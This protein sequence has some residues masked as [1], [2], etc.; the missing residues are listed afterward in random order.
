MEL[1]CLVK[2][3]IGG[4]AVAP[5]EFENEVFVE[6]AN[7]KLL[8]CVWKLSFSCLR[9]SVIERT[10]D[11]ER[12]STD[13]LA[14][15]NLLRAHAHTHTRHLILG[16]LILNVVVC[17]KIQS[18]KIERSAG[19]CNSIIENSAKSSSFVYNRIGAS[20]TMPR[21]GFP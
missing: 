21:L 6:L 11:N 15:R 10:Q 19:T 14:K 12:D 20:R 7:N 16:I 13:S 9:L 3:H 18:W 1:S 17:S 4:H 5:V 2:S 8:P